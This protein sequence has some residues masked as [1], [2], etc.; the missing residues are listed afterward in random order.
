MK[1]EYPDGVTSLQLGC[2]YRRDKRVTSETQD[3]I[4]LPPALKKAKLAE[5]KVTWDGLLPVGTTVSASHFKAGQYI[6]V[7]GTTI[8]KGFQGTMKRWGFKG[9]SASHGNT[10]A[11]RLAGS[12]GQCQD[13][14]KVFKGKKMAGHMGARQRTVLSCWV[15]KVSKGKRAL[16]NNG[17]S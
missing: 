11:H 13:P 7:T 14:G 2:G 3:E 16:H 8:G 9:G 4:P 10:K 17:C 5:F 1:H 6:D 12:T 15:Y